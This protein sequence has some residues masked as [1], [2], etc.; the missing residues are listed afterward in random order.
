MDIPEEKKRHFESTQPVRR[1]MK[2]FLFGE[3]NGAHE[4]ISAN[5]QNAAVWK[6]LMKITS[7]WDYVPERFRKTDPNGHWI[8]HYD[9][10]S[11]M[12]ISEYTPE[13][14][15]PLFV[16]EEAEWKLTGNVSP[17]SAGKCGWDS[18]TT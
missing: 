8:G 14:C 13:A 18:V 15:I 16:R 10:H 5:D 17:Y 12:F 4:I 2:E 9:S 6:F 1:E 7:L 3:P 11:D